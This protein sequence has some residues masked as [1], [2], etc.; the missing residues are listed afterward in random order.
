MDPHLPAP[1]QGA[2]LAALVDQWTTRMV[3]ANQASTTIGQR[4]DTVERLLRRLRVNPVTATSDDIARFLALPTER[5]GKP[6]S[7]ASRDTYYRDLSAW[8]SHLKAVHVRDDNPL[9]NLARPKQPR[10]VPRPI[11]VPVI[12]DLITAAHGNTKAWMM[13]A[14]LEGLR[15]ADCAAF[16][17]DQIDGDRIY[18][19]GKGGHIDCLPAH[20]RV[21]KLAAFYPRTAWWFPARGTGTRYPHVRPESVTRAVSE[22]FRAHGIRTGSI[23]RCRHSYA[24]H[25]LQMGVNIRVVQRLMRHESLDT[26][27]GYLQVTDQET[28]DAIHRIPDPI[29]EQRPPP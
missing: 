28:A 22:H 12:S 16:R 15:A 1:T 27:A 9:D 7:P 2:D 29:D 3:A 11:T 10:R 5:G 13:L 4:I 14:Y 19:E 21:L 24:T 8:Y 20:P 25:L 18:V 17:G 26:T 6:L 23:H